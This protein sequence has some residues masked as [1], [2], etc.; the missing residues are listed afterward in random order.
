MGKDAKV[1]DHSMATVGAISKD[2]DGME[3]EGRER[4]DDN[5]FKDMGDIENEDFIYVFWSVF[6]ILSSLSWLKF[7]YV[8]WYIV[9]TTPT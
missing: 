4:D 8:E 1:I 3:Q 9:G 7:L 2:D 5:A 6:A